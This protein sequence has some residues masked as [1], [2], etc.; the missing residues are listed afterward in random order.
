VGAIIHGTSELCPSMDG[1]LY[2]YHV[3]AGTTTHIRSL[4]VLRL[5]IF[6]LT[7]SLRCLCA[8]KIGQSCAILGAVLAL[9]VF[10]LVVT[11]MKLTKEVR[12]TALR[13][14][15]LPMQCRSSAD[16]PSL[17]VCADWV[18]LQHGV[19]RHHPVAGDGLSGDGESR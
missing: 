2:T 14:S 11:N 13:C 6:G 4:P 5:C 12:A 7:F 9:M 10:V 3:T 19:L 16:L 18:L 15:Q 1:N 8:G 17:F